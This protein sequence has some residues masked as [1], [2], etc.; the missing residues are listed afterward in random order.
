M[1]SMIGKK[2]KY[3]MKTIDTI[4]IQSTN[5]NLKFKVAKVQ[6]LLYTKEALVLFTKTTPESDF[7]SLRPG[8]ETAPTIPPKMQ[9]STSHII[10]IVGKFLPKVQIGLL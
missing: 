3:Q 2:W 8:M 4:E 6:I 5:R 7:L 10:Y 9:M 1:Y